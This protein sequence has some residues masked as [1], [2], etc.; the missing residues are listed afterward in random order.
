MFQKECNSKITSDMVHNQNCH[1]YLLQL[2]PFVNNDIVALLPQLEPLFNLDNEYNPQFPYGTLYSSIINYLDAQIDSVDPQHLHLLDELLFAIYH[3]NNHI[4]EDTGWIN[5]ILAQTRPLHT[6][7][8]KMI[9]QALTDGAETVNQL[10]PEKAE[11][12]WNR[13]GGL[14]SSEFHPQHDTNLPSLKNF[15][16]KEATAPVEYRFST[17][18]QRHQDVVSISPL[19]RHWLRINAQNHPQ[20][21][22]LCH[23][24]FNNLGL[25]REHFFDLPGFKE[26]QMSLALHELEKD[27][28]LKVAVITLPASQSLMGAHHYEQTGDQLSCS[29]VFEELF[30]VAQGNRHPSG[31]SDFYISPAIKNLL[32]TDAAEESAI[33][34]AL[35][36]NSFDLMGAQENQTISTA[37]KQAIWLHFIKFELTDFIIEKLSQDNPDL[38][39][40]FSCKDAIDRGMLSSVYYNLFKSFQLDQP[41]QHAEFERALHA[42]AATVKGRGM[43]FHHNIIWNAVDTL[44]NAQYDVLFADKRTS[45]L[46]YWRDMNCPH[47]RVEQLLPIRLEQCEKQFATLPRE[48]EQIK[49]TGLRLIAQIREQ[50]QFSGQRLLLEVVSRTARMLEDKPQP[51]AITDYQNLASE[52]RINHPLLHVIGGLMELLLG[53][54]LY[55]PSLG[56]SQPLVSKGLATAKAGFFARE[57]NQLCDDVVE[58]ASQYNNCPVVA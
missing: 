43:N 23:I 30:R 6:D 55:L 41:M 1:A 2:K 52:L 16:Y 35:L 18:A 5:R 39:Y 17:Q 13:I 50:Q 26:K 57:R 32:F 11:S 8:H 4:L 10:S 31:I 54:L 33:I 48:Q 34:K 45:W 14:F 58:L 37:Q 49:T 7:A 29:D 38:S 15:T 46:I 42:G 3:N 44:V 51:D 27:P 25:D 47:S 28:T 21:Q 56:Y 40:N 9:A 19:F 53:A 22:S 36:K 20:E 24:Y 12:L